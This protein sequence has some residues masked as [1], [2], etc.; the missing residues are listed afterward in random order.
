MRR[1]RHDVRVIE[2]AR[3]HLRG[4][5]AGD[6]RHVREQKR[7]HLVRDGAHLRVVVQARIRG[8]AGDDELRSERG[9]ELVARLVI[10]EPGGLVQAVRHRLE[11]DAHR[12]DLLRVRL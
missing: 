8:R 2:R 9:R 10:D 11:K 5:Q 1:R 12:A 3:D 4:D 7:A 6:V